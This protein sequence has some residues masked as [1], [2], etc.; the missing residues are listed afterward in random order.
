[1]EHAGYPSVSIISS[2]FLKQAAVVAKG[3]GLP[4][5]AIAEYPG[6]PMT[7]SQEELRRKVETKLLPQ[8]VDGLSRSL[9]SQST[10]AAAG[11]AW[12]IGCVTRRNV[13]IVFCA[14][15]RR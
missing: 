9:G 14:D 4:D 5:M 11:R 12:S 2:G 6:V 13:G 3:L 1:M 8:I 15:I 7:D 10:V